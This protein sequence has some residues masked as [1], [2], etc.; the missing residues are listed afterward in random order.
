MNEDIKDKV[1]DDDCIHQIGRLTLGT[2]GLLKNKFNFQNGFYRITPNKNIYVKFD[3]FEAIFEAVQETNPYIPKEEEEAD[4]NNVEDQ[5]ENKKDEND[6][7]E[8]KEDGNNDKNND[9]DEN[10]NNDEDNNDED[11][12]Y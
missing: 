3:G 9:N 6:D 4:K 12:E 7:E 2:D 10:D 1:S 5:D 8:E 11:N